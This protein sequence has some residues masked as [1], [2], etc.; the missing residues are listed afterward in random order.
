MLINVNK[1]KKHNGKKNIK[2]IN[3]YKFKLEYILAEIRRYLL[4]ILKTLK[5]YVTNNVDTLDYRTP[6]LDYFDFLCF[7]MK[8]MTAF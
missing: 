8:E 7:C 3:L 5:L 2:Y 1:N 4:N 6:I